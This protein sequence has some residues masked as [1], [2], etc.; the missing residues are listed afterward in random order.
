[1]YI[2][3]KGRSAESLRQKCFECTLCEALCQ[4]CKFVS[5]ALTCSA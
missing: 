3:S 2:E 5:V 1:M 4:P